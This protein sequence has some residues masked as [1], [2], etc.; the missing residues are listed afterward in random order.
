MDVFRAVVES[1]AQVSG[2][3]NEDIADELC[4]HDTLAEVSLLLFLLFISI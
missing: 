2:C 3:N 4:S 1:S